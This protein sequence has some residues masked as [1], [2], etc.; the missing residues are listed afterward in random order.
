VEEPETPRS[1]LDRL[2]E[3]AI[4]MLGALGFDA[5]RMRWRW[6]RYRQQMQQRRLDAGNRLRAVTGKHRMCRSCR[7]LVPVDSRV[8]TECGA[9]LAGTGRPGVGRL[10]QWALPGIPQITAI[11][12]SVNFAI[13]LLVGLR[14]G[15]E[16]MSGSGG[17]FGTLFSLMSFSSDTLIRYGS[18]NNFLLLFHGDWW[19]LI[20]PIFLHA[21]LLHLLFNT[22]I[23]VQIGPLMEEEYGREKF[24]VL[25]LVAGIGSFFVSQILRYYLLG[26]FVNTIGAS[27]S[28]FGLVGAALVFG[29]R[30]GGPYGARLRSMMIQWTI[31]FLVMGFLIR[32]TDN[33]AHIG[34][35]ASGAAF[36]ALTSLEA[37]KGGAIPVWR[38]VAILGVALVVTAILFAGV[39]GL[40]SLDWFRDVTGGN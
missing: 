15:F 1:S 39:Y 32:G 29:Y 11:I 35:L 36:A 9:S 31:Y 40:D 10:F 37:P 26:G 33:F 20:C 27:G 23:F 4:E 25:Y 6:N 14:A 12:L 2:V 22:Y 3:R 30:R 13:F 24:F 5:T 19:R 38:A 34:G 18:G 21:G 7:A 28:I 16:P 17:L 8:C